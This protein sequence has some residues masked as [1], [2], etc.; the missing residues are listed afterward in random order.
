VLKSAKTIFYIFFFL[1]IASL[2]DS[3]AQDVFQDVV[4]LKNGKILKGKI[5][6][7]ENQRINFV[8]ETGTVLTIGMEDVSKIRTEKNKSKWSAKDTVF[9]AK[10]FVT[11]AELSYASGMGQINTRIGNFKNAQDGYCLSVS[12]GYLVAP[13]V[14]IGLGAGYDQYT[15]FQ[16]LPLFFDLRSDFFKDRVRPMFHLKFGHSLGWSEGNSGADWG[17]F[18]IQADL[19]VKLMLSHSRAL[20]F[21]LGLKSQQFKIGYFFLRNNA[22][23]L[24][25]SERLGHGF[26][27]INAGFSF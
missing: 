21:S 3:Y 16:T 23:P 24:F 13:T 17:G 1:L 19:G 27:T 12:Y 15:T 8:S 7:I 14:F 2:S 26:V 9:K 18:M 22:P 20:H 25:A 10:G 11:V 4:Y 5:Q 6:S